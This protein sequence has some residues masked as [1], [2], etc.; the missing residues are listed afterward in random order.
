MSATIVS[1]SAVEAL[2]TMRVRAQGG[3]LRNPEKAVKILSKK[4]SR[5]DLVDALANFQVSATEDTVYG[6]IAEWLISVAAANEEIQAE[7][8]VTIQR[9]ALERQDMLPA[10]E[11]SETLP[12]APESSETLPLAKKTRR[13]L[14]PPITDNEKKYIEIN[15]GLY[16]TVLRTIPTILVE[17][18]KSNRRAIKE[19]LDG[20]L[21][22]PR[23]ARYDDNQRLWM[24][25]HLAEKLVAEKKIGR[26][27]RGR[28][29]FYRS[30]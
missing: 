3:E 24:T 16:T 28:D 30:I 22:H 26:E 5:I 13:N 7:E 17:T 9:D 8:M 19:A 11:S 12:L 15:G 27:K 6:E 2:D 10:P 1:N 21:I 23:W 29:V 14:D 25:S 20:S 4:F 18:G